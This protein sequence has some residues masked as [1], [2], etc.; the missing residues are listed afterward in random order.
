MPVRRAPITNPIIPGAG[1][2]E[3]LRSGHRKRPPATR[4]ASPKAP[5]R[6]VTD[7][8]HAVIAVFRL[9]RPGRVGPGHRLAPSVTIAGQCLVTAPPHQRCPHM[10]VCPRPAPM[11]V[12]CQSA[13]VAKIRATV[14]S[15]S[16]TV[17]IA[18]TQVPFATRSDA[19]CS[20]RSRCADRRTSSD[21][22]APQTTS[23]P[24]MRLST[25]RTASRSSSLGSG[26]S[27]WRVL[28]SDV[29]QVCARRG[30]LSV[31][32]RAGASR[33]WSPSG[34]TAATSPASGQGPG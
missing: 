30:S 21:W 26:R 20:A 27:A 33:T 11:R 29:P 15:A 7:R 32:R 31:D 22:L 16:T 25:R 9:S 10:S 34:P 13:S 28:S 17:A 1:I 18:S 24:P 19:S 14:A 3:S 5:A 6:H 23:G 8:R 12:C 4:R 2:A